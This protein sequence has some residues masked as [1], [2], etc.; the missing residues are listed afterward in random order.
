LTAT[1]EKYNTSENRAKFLQLFQTTKFLSLAI[2]DDSADCADYADAAI[3]VQ[4][5]SP[6]RVARTCV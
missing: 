2:R 5:F 6:N 4:A 3:A 1:K